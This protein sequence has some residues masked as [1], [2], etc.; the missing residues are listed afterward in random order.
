M[1]LSHLGRLRAPR[2]RPARQE[3]RR[4]DKITPQPE[5]HRPGRTTA[6]RCTASHP[7]PTRMGIT[8]YGHRPVPN[9]F[10]NAELQSNG[11]W[12]GALQEPDLR[13][14]M[15]EYVAALD[16]AQPARAKADPGAAP[17]RDAEHLP[18]LLLLPHR[19]EERT[20]SDLEPPPRATRQRSGPGSPRR[21][22]RDRRSAR[23]LAQAASLLGVVTLLLLSMHRLH[24]GAN[25]PPGD[26]GRPGPRPVRLPEGGRGAERPAR[27]GPADPHAVLRLDQR[28]LHRRHRRIVASGSRSAEVI[29]P[30]LLNSAKLAPLA[31]MIVVPLAILG[32]VIAALTR[33]YPRPGDHGRRPVGDGVPEF[34]W[35]VVLIIVFSLG[36][37]PLPVDCERRRRA[38]APDVARVPAAAGVLPRFVLFGYIARM[39]RAA[40]S[41][42]STPTTRARRSSRACPSARCSHHVLRN[43]LLP[44]IA[45]V[46][47]QVGLPD[48]RARR[49]RADL[50]LPRARPDD[51]PGRQQKDFP[52]CRAR[53]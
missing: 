10:L 38:R 36:L 16:L 1:Q 17:R 22:Q 44:T 30:A 31:F 32:G 13:H 20:S 34:V 35:A 51:L 39:A 23:F 50:Q 41:R 8:D 7:G 29:G 49:R 4:G 9:V 6:T 3:E 18:V 12:N 21:D 14:L 47:T 26:V 48:R 46:A 28:L 53:C 15:G 37:G 33:E 19:D 2:P 45:V 11:P 5:H 52:C 40:R 43:S 42:R 27:H 24:V 25:V